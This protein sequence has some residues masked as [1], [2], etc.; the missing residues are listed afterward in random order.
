MSSRSPLLADQQERVLAV[1]EARVAVAWDPDGAVWYVRT[2]SVPGL[3]A[4]GETLAELEGSL[5]GL[6]ALIQLP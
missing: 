2:S 1:G 4:E 3:A 6:I 5:P